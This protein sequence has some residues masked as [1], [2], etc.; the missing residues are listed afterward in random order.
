[1]TVITQAGQAGTAGSGL[2]RYRDVL[3][4]PGALAFAIP[5]VVGRMP[6]MPSLKHPNT[7]YQSIADRSRFERWPYLA[8]SS[9][10]AGIAVPGRDGQRPGGDHHASLIVCWQRRETPQTIAGTWPHRALMVTGR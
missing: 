2:A 4:T 7:T 5:G 10:G 9:R 8:I 6:T 3:R 1:M